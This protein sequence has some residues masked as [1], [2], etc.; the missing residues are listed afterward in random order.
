MHYFYFENE[1]VKFYTWVSHCWKEPKNCVKLG[2]IADKNLGKATCAC[3]KFIICF[4]KICFT[5]PQSLTVS[6]LK[7]VKQTQVF[8]ISLLVEATI[9]YTLPCFQIPFV[10]ISLFCCYPKSFFL[11]TAWFIVVLSRKSCTC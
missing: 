10:S 3:V 4:L 9:H 6:V 1:G 11:R 2:R 7:N 5:H 8:F